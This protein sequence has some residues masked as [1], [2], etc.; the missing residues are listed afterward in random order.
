MILAHAYDELREFAEKTQTPV[1]TTLMG[2]SCFPTN[3]VLYA[4]WPG[5]HG[6]AYASLA[7]EEADLL[8]ALGMRFDDRITGNPAL[9]ALNS[10]KIHVDIDP[11]EIGKNVPADLPIV[12]DLKLTLA[13]L[14]R[15][16]EPGSHLD[17]LGRID[18]LKREHPLVDPNDA[19]ALQIR[20]IIQQIAEATDG[21]ALIVTGVGQHQMWAAQHYPFKQRSSLISSCGSGAM[22]Y[23]VPGAMGA[24]VG[25]PD[26][27]VWSIAGDGG[28]QMTMA[29][30][31]TLVENRIPVK[32]AIMNNNCLGMV[33]AV[34][35]A[36][37]REELR[38]HQV[39][40]QPGLRETGRG[41]R[42]A[43]LEG[44]RQA[45]GEN[46]HRTGDELRRPRCGRLRRRARGQRVPHDSSG[47]HHRTAD[48]RAHAPEGEPM[49]MTDSLSRHT[50]TALVNDRPGVLN[51]VSSMFRRRGFNISSLAVGQSELPDLSRMTF[52]VEGDQA[53]VEQVTKHLHKLIDVVKVTDMSN[54]NTVT[55]ELGLI[56][57][58]SNFQTRG[59]IMQIADIFRA[60]IVDLAPDSLIIEVTGDEDKIDSLQNLLGAFGVLE[61]MRTGKIALTRG[62]NAAAS[63]ATSHGRMRAPLGT[64]SV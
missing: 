57:V 62:M 24:Q 37:L 40:P 1:I 20:Y 21:D 46:G 9:F 58:R 31:A 44:D 43:G 54:E 7:I 51:R 34:A 45:P 27:V 29:E 38:R 47:H 12:G 13:A 25:R 18:Q 56:R 2:V 41:L 30:L 4:G 55:R 49:T 59:E 19:Q 52:V 28:F 61:V 35:A 32:F 50:I 6:M 39:H 23:E 33:S 64:G 5:M 22:G 11:S 17:W 3:H 53:V 36:L 16:V 14:S 48:G 60:H 42:N 10:K 8:I 63:R 15:Q 26:K